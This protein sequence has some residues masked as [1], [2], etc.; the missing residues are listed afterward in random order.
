MSTKIDQIKIKQV[1]TFNY[2]GSLITDDGK[3]DSKI[4]KR[5]GMSKEAFQKLSTVLKDMKMPMEVKKSRIM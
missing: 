4:K 1:N 5:I 3:C 2:L